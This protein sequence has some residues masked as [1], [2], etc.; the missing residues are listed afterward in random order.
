MLVVGDAAVASASSSAREAEEKVAEG[1]ADAKKTATALAVGVPRDSAPF[2]TPAPSASAL[3]VEHGLKT[4]RP[5]SMNPSPIKGRKGRRK[6]RSERI[7]EELWT[8]LEALDGRTLREPRANS[9]LR[10]QGDPLLC[11]V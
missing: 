10:N 8:L 7:M 1:K 4:E 2:A 5:P 11:S 6:E 3:R 9:P